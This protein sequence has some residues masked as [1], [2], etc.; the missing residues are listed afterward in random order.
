ME[1]KFTSSVANKARIAY[2]RRNKSTYAE[3]FERQLNKGFFTG[4]KYLTQ[5]LGDRW[6]FRM[7]KKCNRMIAKDRWAHGVEHSVDIKRLLDGKDIWKSIETERVRLF[8]KGQLSDESISHN[9]I[10]TAQANVNDELWTPGANDIGG[11]QFFVDQGM[12]PFTFVVTD[13]RDLDHHA[14]EHPTY[15]FDRWHLLES[16]FSVADFILSEIQ[17]RDAVQEQLLAHAPYPDDETR[18][19]TNV[20]HPMSSV[21]FAVKDSARVQWRIEDRYRRTWFYYRKDAALDMGKSAGSWLRREYRNC[22]DCTH[23][24]APSGDENSSNGDESDD[25]QSDDNEFPDGQSPELIPED[26]WQEILTGQRKKEILLDGDE[27]HL[28]NEIDAD[29]LYYIDNSEHGSDV[30]SFVTYGSPF[31]VLPRFATPVD[32]LSDNYSP[33]EFAPISDFENHTSGND[34]RDSG[35]AE[36]LTPEPMAFVSDIDSDYNPAYHTSSHFTQNVIV[37]VLT[38]E[39]TVYE[40]ASDGERDHSQT[41]TA[42]VDEGPSPTLTSDHV[43]ESVI[44]WQEI[45]GGYEAGDEDAEDWIMSAAVSKPVQVDGKPKRNMTKKVLDRLERNSAKTKDFDRKVPRAIVINV[46]INELP[47][48]ALVDTG[49]LSDFMSTKF[50]DQLKAPLLK[51]EKPMFQGIDENRRFDIMNIENYDLILGTPFL[52]QHKDQEI[53]YLLKERTSP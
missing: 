6:E 53:P 36:L 8:V 25:G 9:I 17:L 16:E 1:F 2:P 13:V 52:F 38:D 37:S 48:C 12:T 30:E 18:G 34:A 32:E 39:E 29:M 26:E 50:A 31:V 46:L 4:D 44:A 11:K 21:R 14:G 5:R 22:A 40:T 47:A 20:I 15:Q 23:I 33:I 35:F 10:R 42:P 28:F 19:M 3:L 45:D 24:N 41:L 51:L 27:S 49:G 43:D 7:N